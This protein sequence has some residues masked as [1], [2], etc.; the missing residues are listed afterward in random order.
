M[1]EE[2]FNLIEECTN[3]FFVE[4]LNKTEVEIHIQIPKKFRSLWLKKLSDLSTTMQE[5]D[6]YKDE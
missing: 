3:K 5:I 6:E 2:I 4:E 1:N